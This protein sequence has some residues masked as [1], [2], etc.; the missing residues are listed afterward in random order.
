MK[1]KA[2]LTVYSHHEKL[3]E[4]DVSV[5]IPDYKALIY[6]G[7]TKLYKIE[8]IDKYVEVKAIDKNI[9]L[10][11]QKYDKDNI[12]KIQSVIDFINDLDDWMISYKYDNR[13]EVITDESIFNDLITDLSYHCDK[14]GLYLLNFH[15][16]SN[17]SDDTVFYNIKVLIADKYHL[18]PDDIEQTILENGDIENKFYIIETAELISEKG[19]MILKPK[20]LD[21]P[22]LHTIY[23]SIN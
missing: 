13:Y 16:N 11:N 17:I 15:N 20:K 3:N 22:K 2:K 18:S 1:K 5:N 8:V 7:N 21:K 4:I 14:S 9:S 10:I 12:N 19:E 23:Y 6:S